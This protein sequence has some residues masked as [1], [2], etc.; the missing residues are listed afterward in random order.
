MFSMRCCRCFDQMSFKH[1]FSVTTEGFIWNKEFKGRCHTIACR[2][3][4]KG[5]DRPPAG[6]QG[7]TNG[8]LWLH[9]LTTWSNLDE[10]FDEVSDSDDVVGFRRSLEDGKDWGRDENM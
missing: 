1:M 5:S 8:G 9:I 10:D 7:W 6:N 4:M 2:L 3:G